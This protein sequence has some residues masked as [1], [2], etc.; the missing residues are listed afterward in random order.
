L[1]E[2]REEGRR[3]RT[4]LLVIHQSPLEDQVLG[5]SSPIELVVVDVENRQLELKVIWI[6]DVIGRIGVNRERSD[7][8]NGGKW[9]WW[10]NGW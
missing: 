1:R 7:Y 3:Q 2:R 6:F 10:R 9:W 5:L 4:Y 8:N